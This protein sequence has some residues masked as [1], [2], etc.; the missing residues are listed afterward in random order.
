MK[1][2]LTQTTVKRGVKQREEVKEIS[3]K[4]Y[5]LLTNNDTLKFFR[6]LGGTETVRKTYTCKGLVITKLIST[7]P[8]KEI[9]VVREFNFKN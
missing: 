9:K 8:D 4:E 6:R 7:S 1:I 3:E 5:N 2:I